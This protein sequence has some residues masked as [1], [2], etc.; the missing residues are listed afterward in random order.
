MKAMV[1]QNQG[2]K[3]RALFDR[4]HLPHREQVIRNTL[5]REGFWLR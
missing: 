3:V 2:R 1:Y 4:A 5:K